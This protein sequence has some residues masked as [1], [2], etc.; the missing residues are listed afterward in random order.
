MEDTLFLSVGVLRVTSQIFTGPLSL[1][2]LDHTVVQWSVGR[3]TA[4]C[5][6]SLTLRGFPLGSPPSLHSVKNTEQ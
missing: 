6:F 3:L 1:T 4:G 5:G 2:P